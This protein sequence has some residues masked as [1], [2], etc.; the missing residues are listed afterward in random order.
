MREFGPSYGANVLF[1]KQLLIN[2]VVHAAEQ[3]RAVHSSDRTT[4]APEIEAILNSD[5]YDGLGWAIDGDSSSLNSVSLGTIG[6]RRSATWILTP[7]P[8]TGDEFTLLVSARSDEAL[9]P[10]ACHCD[11][12]FPDMEVA[13]F[14][15]YSLHLAGISTVDR[16]VYE[17]WN[18]IQKMPDFEGTRPRSSGSCS[19]IRSAIWMVRQPTASSIIV[20]ARTRR[21]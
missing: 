7:S 17:L 18:E 20:K 13:H 14:G 19:R 6:A 2:A 16:L 4:V 15:S 11:H 3:G 12:V 1:P 21:A 5:N 8:A 9:F 10:G